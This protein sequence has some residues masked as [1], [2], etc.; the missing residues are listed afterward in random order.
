MLCSTKDVL[1]YSVVAT[2]GTVGLPCLHLRVPVYAR[3][4]RDEPLRWRTD[5][6][7][8]PTSATMHTR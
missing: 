1:N 3:L 7:G 2:D 5:H 6:R 4:G 8:N